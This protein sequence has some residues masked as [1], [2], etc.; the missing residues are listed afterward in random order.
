MPQRIPMTRGSSALEGRG[1]R[2]YASPSQTCASAG[3]LK[4]CIRC[5]LAIAMAAM[6]MCQSRL[7]V[8]TATPSI[9][10]RCAAFQ[11]TK[12]ER[13]SRSYPVISRQS[14][15]SGT[16]AGRAARDALAR[17]SSASRAGRVRWPV[18]TSSTLGEDMTD[19][20]AYPPSSYAGSRT[21]SNRS[22]GGA[23]IRKASRRPGT[24]GVWRV[25][26][27]QGSPAAS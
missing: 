7:R 3:V 12:R 2:D 4:A 26:A 24:A 11:L 21:R 6:T 22:S 23:R 1:G 18:S 8:T 27:T 25:L 17:P 19:S 5:P 16:D 20:T 13:A 14:T 9:R 15:R 10:E